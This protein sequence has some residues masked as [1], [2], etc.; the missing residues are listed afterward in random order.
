MSA[1]VYHLD[2]GALQLPAGFR[3]ATINVFEW[4]D[5]NGR[6]VLTIQREKLG[7]QGTFAE[8]VD[9]ITAPY[10]KLFASYEEEE[11]MEIA[12][13]VPVV[14]KRFRWR[15]PQGVLYHRSSFPRFGSRCHDDD[16]G[17]DGRHAS[18]RGRGA[19][20]SAAR[21]AAAG[22]KLMP[23]YMEQQARV[24]D[25]VAHVR[26]TTTVSGSAWCS[27][28]GVSCSRRFTIAGAIAVIGTAGFVQGLGGVRRPAA[29]QGGH[30]AYRSGRRDRIRR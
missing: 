23:H 7:E 16:R 6:L 1:Y 25:G 28:R 12:M 19:A 24:T 22:A 2:E 5:A 8:L 26:P 10:P 20:R 3:D 18:S 13:D 30:R 9:K 29:P 21:N 15:Q 27:S 4:A 11:P 17:R 14:S